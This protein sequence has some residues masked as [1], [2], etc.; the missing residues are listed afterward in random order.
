MRHYLTPSDPHILYPYTWQ[1]DRIRLT[2]TPYG[3]RTE[4]RF[5]GTG[6]VLHPGRYLVL[7]READ[8]LGFPLPVIRSIEMLKRGR[9]WKLR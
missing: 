6:L 9:W 8:A 3:T 5:E 7:E 4:S 2:T 1:A